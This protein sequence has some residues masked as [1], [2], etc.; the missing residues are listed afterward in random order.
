MKAYKGFN[1]DFKC[2]GFQ[3]EVGKEYTQDGNIEA[4]RN[5]FH[6]CEYPLDVF[7]YYPPNESRYAEVEQSGDTDKTE[8]KTASRNIKIKAEIGL[9]GLIKAAVDFTFSKAVKVKGSSVR[10]KQGA[11]SATGDYGAASA[12][13]DYGAAS[14]TGFQGAASATGD[15]GAASATGFQGAASATGDYGAASATG[16]Q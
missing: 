1:K 12:T 13:G 2:R 7:N 14:A 10:K 4:C 9:A 8:D 16:F 3:F 11:A 6:A 5:G 15:Y